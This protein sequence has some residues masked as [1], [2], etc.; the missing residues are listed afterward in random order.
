MGA[1]LVAGQWVI[2]DRRSD[3]EVQISSRQSEQAERRENVRFVRDRSADERAPRPFAGMDLGHQNLAG[4]QMSSADLRGA[5]LVGTRLDSAVLTGANL[6]NAGLS[7]TTFTGANLRGADLSCRDEPKFVACN[8]S[9]MGVRF[10][11]ADLAKSDLVD[12]NLSY[13]DLGDANLVEAN[14]RG[15]RFFA[16]KLYAADLSGAI[17]SGTDFAGA[18]YDDLTRWPTEFTPPPP[19]DPRSCN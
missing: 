2:D 11:S 6:T 5:Y 14:L 17:V 16:A 10:V 3:R 19:A 8:G 1:L 12:V 9:A 4:L 7:G 15:A 18:C 13:A